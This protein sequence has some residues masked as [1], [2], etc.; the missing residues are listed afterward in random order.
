MVLVLGNGTAESCRCEEESRV[1]SESISV[2]AGLDDRDA[3]ELVGRPLVAILRR[4]RPD[5][6]LA[7]RSDSL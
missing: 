6:P 1:P 3:A 2:C 4:E 7:P 5:L